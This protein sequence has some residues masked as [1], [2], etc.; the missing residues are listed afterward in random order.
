MNGFILTDE[1]FSHEISVP[2][3]FAPLRAGEIEVDAH[4]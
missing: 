3:A 4:E 2:P 1:R